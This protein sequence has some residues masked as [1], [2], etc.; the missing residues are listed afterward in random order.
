MSNKFLEIVV[1]IFVL[2]FLG[3]PASVL[4]RSLIIHAPNKGIDRL[5]CANIDPDK[6]IIK[7]ANIRK[8]NN[9]LL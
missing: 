9:F 3:G 6:D 2:F 1:S 8:L 5:A 4:G 7:Y